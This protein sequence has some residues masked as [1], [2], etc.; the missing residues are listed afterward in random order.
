MITRI[1]VFV[2]GIVQGVGFRYFTKK[3]AKEL[4]VKGYV[5]NLPDGRVFIV[6]EGE[7]NQLE[8]F[9]SNIR[10]GPP[11]AIVKK[12]HVEKKP[13]TGEFEDFVIAY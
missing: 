4:G 11:L 10:R 12:I 2:E 1:E 8:K 5:K 13:A 9:L 6:A 7:E 3:V